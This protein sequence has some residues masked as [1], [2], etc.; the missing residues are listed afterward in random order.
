MLQR[1]SYCFVTKAIM[2]KGFEYITR[3]RGK[4]RLDL[5]EMSVLSYPCR[6]RS[7]HLHG[8]MEP[9]PGVDEDSVLYPGGRSTACGKQVRFCPSIEV[10]FIDRDICGFS[11]YHYLPNSWKYREFASSAFGRDATRSYERLGERRCKSR[12]EVGDE[13]EC[14]LDQALL[15]SGLSL[16]TLTP[17]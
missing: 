11:L 15:L 12:R 3:G 9:F 7:S 14:D 16:T 4:V 8:R 2:S 17:N 6:E 13:E 1:E 5:P 10:V